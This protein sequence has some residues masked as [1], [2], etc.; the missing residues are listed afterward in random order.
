MKID[1]EGYDLEVL[2]GAESL[3]THQRVD[4]VQVEAGMNRDNHRHVTFILL[5]EYLERF[6]YRL[7]GIYN[8]SGEWP[9][10]QAI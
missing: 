7:F 10:R 3:L 1:T 4:L 5:T 8:Q 2:R 9:A 6:N